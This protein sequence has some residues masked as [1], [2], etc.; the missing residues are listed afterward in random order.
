MHDIMNVKWGNSLFSDVWC[1][2]WNDYESVSSQAGTDECIFGANLNFNIKHLWFHLS[3]GLDC[4]NWLMHAILQY[5]YVNIAN[6][7]A[8]DAWLLW[9]KI[10][11]FAF[12]ALKF[13]RKVFTSTKK[14][15]RMQHLDGKYDGH[16]LLSNLSLLGW[17]KLELVSVKWVKKHYLRWENDE[18]SGIRHRELF[19][20]WLWINDSDG[21]LM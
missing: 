3:R 8:I 9:Y 1:S 21:L 16:C 11:Q 14:R 6:R 19:L 10:S 18:P 7:H 13:H 20:T 12:I 5:K 15:S 17:E 2:K 4:P